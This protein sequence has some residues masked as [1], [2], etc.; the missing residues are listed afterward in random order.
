[1]KL[2]LFDLVL[3]I[4]KDSLLF[5]SH[6]VQEKETKVAKI[7]DYFRKPSSSDSASVNAKAYILAGKSHDARAQVKSSDKEPLTEH[8]SNIPTKTPHKESVAIKKKSRDCD[9][10]L[11]SPDT[12]PP[13][14]PPPKRQK[15]DKL[16]APLMN[17]H[18]KEQDCAA[19]K[20]KPR[21]LI[22]PSTSAISQ[23]SAKK[24]ESRVVNDDSKLNIETI[25]IPEEAATVKKIIKAAK[26]DLYHLGRHKVV[27][28]EKAENGRELRI[29]VV[30]E[31]DTVNTNIK[32]IC[33]LRDFWYSIIYQP[34]KLVK[35]F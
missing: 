15:V 29:V 23:S 4:L 19:T 10:D 28:C 22:P 9:G 17:S 2:I 34:T 32:K 11:A 8:I 33:V 27:E 1:M 26:K 31:D 3:P 5:K 12:I 24:E 18:I 7:S 16:Q 14:P 13:T 21:V 30:P 20:L 35:P 25:S 6:I